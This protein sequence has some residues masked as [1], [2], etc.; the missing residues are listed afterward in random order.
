MLVSHHAEIVRALND[1][2]G[3]R[4]RRS[5]ASP[6]S[7]GSIGPMKHAKAHL[8][9]W[10]KPEK[11]KTTPALLG[12]LG[13]KAEIRFQPKGTIGIISPWNFPV[14]LTF[15]PAGRRAGGRQP[16]DDQAVGVH[17]ATSELMARLFAEAFDEEEI[18]VFPGGPRSARPSP[19]SPSTTWSSPARHPSP[20]T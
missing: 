7:P 15:A 12:M 8:K 11:R 17:A 16:G 5:A 6:T 14:N 3:S 4:A 18:A 2:F 20:A 9:A 1:D 13:A 19:P 10:M